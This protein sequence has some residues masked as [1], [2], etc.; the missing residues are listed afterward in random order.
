[1]RRVGCDGGL[2]LLGLPKSMGLDAEPVEPCLFPFKGYRMVQ[3]DLMTLKLRGTPLPRRDSRSAV[4]TII[5]VYV[6][7]IDPRVSKIFRVEA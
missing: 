3:E 7:I 1:M 6:P 5:V 2:Y 4:V